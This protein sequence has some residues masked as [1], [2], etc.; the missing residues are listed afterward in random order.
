MNKE[1]LHEAYMT[2]HSPEQ[3]DNTDC[4]RSTGL[5]SCTRTYDSTDSTVCTDCD[6]VINCYVCTN[7]VHCVE[8]V[9]CV[10]C[11]LCNGLRNKTSGYWLLNKEVT[12]EEFESA[13][14]TYN[15]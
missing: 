11:F 5:L 1:E 15:S 14:A 9:N 13:I 10:N 6:F 8:C 12:K 7:C 4:D 2:I 3:N